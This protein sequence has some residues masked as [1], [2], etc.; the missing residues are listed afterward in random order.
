[1]SS[2]SSSS[3][4]GAG[5]GNYQTLTSDGPMT[6]NDELA[7]RSMMKRANTMPIMTGK[8][9]KDTFYDI[10]SYNNLP[11]ESVPGLT[12]SEAKQTKLILVTG[13]MLLFQFANRI[14]YKLTTY[15]M[16]NYTLFLNLVTCTVYIPIFFSYV[17][18]MAYTGKIKSEEMNFP[19]T[20]FAFIGFLDGL[21][22]TLQN[23]SVNF[24][25]NAALII[26]IQQAAIP[27]SMIISAYML[28]H[29]YN[30][31]QYTGA[32]M[33][34]SGILISLLP[35]LVGQAP[36]TGV[37]LTPQEKGWNEIFWIAVLALS[38]IP[39]CLS[40]IYKEATLVNL[41]VD[42]AYLA[43]M[44]A[45]WQTIFSLMMSIPMA[46]LAGTPITDLPWYFYDGFQCVCGKN[47]ILE[48]TAEK[49][50]DDCA[51]APYMIGF[52]II[53]NSGFQFLITLILKYG[54]A[55]LLRM[56][57]AIMVPTCNVAFSLPIMPRSIPMS[58]SDF[59]GLLFVMS[60][61]IVYRFINLVYTTYNIMVGYEY[62]E[63]EEED[64]EDDEQKIDQSIDVRSIINTPVVYPL[65]LIGSQ[66]LRRNTMPENR[67][68]EMNIL[69]GDS[70]TFNIS[71]SDDNQ[72][73]G[74][75]YLDSP[76]VMAESTRSL[77][78][79]GLVMDERNGVQA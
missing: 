29:S 13:L 8:V 64:A 56:A 23:V 59:I 27:F 40:S 36:T 51:N 60:G 58:P 34:V 31:T 18:P 70:S 37:T 4:T 66:L 38:Q 2:S 20:Q 57:S 28:G 21:S 76:V 48:A 55:N 68:T 33:V 7:D 53:A 69:H 32:I 1:M 12:K 6:N 42:V 77:S 26:L 11:S 45:F 65:K 10:E 50:A 30:V 15:S 67:S 5:A 74:S 9:F 62:F 75:P 54:T 19:I 61:L 44:V 41:D 35:T 24:V 72:K 17:V 71:N 73:K 78:L 49:P 46:P 39:I 52:L 25:V 79:T 14:M 16:Y 22:N 47:T 63:L 43:A 3:S